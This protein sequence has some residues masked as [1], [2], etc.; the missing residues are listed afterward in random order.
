MSSRSI[1]M[2]LPMPER[3]SDSADQDP[4]PPNP[5]TATVAECK[6]FSIVETE[7]WSCLL[8]LEAY[9]RATPANRNPRS[10]LAC[11]VAVVVDM[12][13]IMSLAGSSLRLIT[14]PSHSFAVE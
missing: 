4:I 12:S 3:T 14:P 6:R 7:T 2:I 9:N 1:R 5:M 8:V 13:S 11:C 10:M